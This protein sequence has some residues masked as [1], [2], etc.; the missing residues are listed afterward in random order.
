PRNARTAAR[1]MTWS[2]IFSGRSAFSACSDCSAR[3]T[4]TATP[5]TRFDWPNGRIVLSIFKGTLKMRTTPMMIAA[6]ALITASPALAQNYAA[7]ASTNVAET[8]VADMNAAANV[9]D[10]SPMP[11]EPV[12]L[13]GDN[14]EN[15]TAPAPAP[16]K[17]S[18][19]W[20]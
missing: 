3:A 2:R 14:V 11:A 19:P 17:R 18:F 12:V 8:N 6:V 10:A 9:A 16:A 15:E 20:G 5:T 1:T 4:T 13:P 7:N